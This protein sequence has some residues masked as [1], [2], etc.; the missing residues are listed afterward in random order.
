MKVIKNSATVKA[1]REEG[2]N[3]QVNSGNMSIEQTTEGTQD[4]VKVDENEKIICIKGILENLMTASSVEKTIATF[5]LEN[6]SSTT[7][8]DLYP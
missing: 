8:M 6:F 5:F 7:I 2:V 4:E 1:V 3:T